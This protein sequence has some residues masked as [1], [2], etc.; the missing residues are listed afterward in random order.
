MNSLPPIISCPE[1]IPCRQV[2]HLR[3]WQT[4]QA[5]HLTREHWTFFSSCCSLQ[6]GKKA[7]GRS[8]RGKV[9]CISSCQ[10]LCLCRV[11]CRGHLQSVSMDTCNIIGTRPA[12]L[13]V[14][15]SVEVDALFGIYAPCIPIPTSAVNGPSRWARGQVVRDFPT[16]SRRLSTNQ[17][18][19]IKYMDKVLG[20]SSA[21]PNLFRLIV[22]TSGVGVIT[23]S[24]PSSHG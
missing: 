23:S 10:T 22:L 24:M 2:S 21:S 16:L 4:H 7:S 18:F 11:F 5:L 13:E 20:P 17:S 15:S 12:H 6:P 19:F 8:G 14:Q 9:G 3:G 1:S